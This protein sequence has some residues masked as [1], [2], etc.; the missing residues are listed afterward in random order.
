MFFS[1]SREVIFLILQRGKLAQISTFIGGEFF[2]VPKGTDTYGLD[3]HVDCLMC[4]V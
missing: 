2:P 4:T 1:S 3:T